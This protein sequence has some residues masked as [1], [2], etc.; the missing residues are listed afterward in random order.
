MDYLTARVKQVIGQVTQEEEWDSVTQLDAIIAVETWFNV[1]FSTEIISQLTSPERIAARMPTTKRLPCRRKKCVVFDLDDTIWEGTIGEVGHE[2]LKV[3]PGHAGLQEFLLSLRDEGVLLAIASKND[4]DHIQGVFECVPDMVLCW[5]D[6]TLAKIGWGPKHLSIAAIAEELGFHPGTLLF[7]DNSPHERSLVREM[8]PEVCTPHLEGPPADYVSQAKRCPG[9]VPTT[10]ITD[11]DRQRAEMMQQEFLRA[12]ARSVAND[13]EGYLEGLK[14]EVK[15]EPINPEDLIRA[16]QLC[17]RTNQFNFNLK[18]YDQE[19]LKNMLDIPGAVGLMV[20]VSDR[21][22]KAGRVGAAMAVPKIP[23]KTS[24]TI[25]WELLVLVLSCRVLGRGVEQALLAE[26]C[27]RVYEQG[28]QR[29]EGGYVEGP[30]NACCLLTL[31]SLGLCSP[32]G[33]DLVVDLPAEQLAVPKFL[34]L[35]SPKAP[36]DA[37]L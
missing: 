4:P 12:Q 35:V 20:S 7:L 31:R 3:T 29:L 28:G 22:G 10:D 23:K 32:A 14:Q 6:I 34:S 26:L 25:T 30:R 37:G 27:R 18:R 15:V 24:T 21:F 16:E 9:L 1:E 17:Q 13:L 5:D 8:L 36:Q 19:S 11:E 2:H 33:Y